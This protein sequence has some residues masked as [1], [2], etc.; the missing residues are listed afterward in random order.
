VYFTSTLD[1]T[2]TQYGVTPDTATPRILA[3]NTSVSVNVV[4]P[5]GNVPANTKTVI[6]HTV[7]S[8]DENYDGLVVPPVSPYLFATDPVIQ[9]EKYAYTGVTDDSTPAQIQATGILV[10]SGSRMVQGT[11]TWFVFKVT[12]TSSDD[13]VTTLTGIQVTDDV[14]G[15]IGTVASLASGASTWLSYGPYAMQ[16]NAPAPPGYTP[17]PPAGP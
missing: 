15:D 10:A 11:P 16:A 1:A 2:A 13:W 5:E 17:P 14:L 3:G 8:A 6:S 4:A 9:V 7:S 12:N